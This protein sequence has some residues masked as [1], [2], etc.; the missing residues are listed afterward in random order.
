MDSLS[1]TSGRLFKISEAAEMLSISR[2]LLYELVRAGRVK[3]VHIG[4]AVRV[5]AT[6]LE[7]FVAELTEEAANE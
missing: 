1:N 5:R 7:R 2:S 3:T 6:E 4:S